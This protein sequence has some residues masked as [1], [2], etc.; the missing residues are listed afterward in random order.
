MSRG[1]KPRRP[2]CVKAEGIRK[3]SF[4]R[5]ILPGQFI[6]HQ[7]R[8]IAA[9]LEARDEDTGEF[10]RRICPEELA[11]K[12]PTHLDEGYKSQGN[13]KSLPEDSIMDDI[14]KKMTSVS[15]EEQG[16]VEQVGGVEEP[17]AVVTDTRYDADEEDNADDEQ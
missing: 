12:K 15:L 5:P 2:K 17:E 1:L 13:K 4:R 3:H 8:A 11:T 7:S 14:N 6:V 9:L 10:T 16:K